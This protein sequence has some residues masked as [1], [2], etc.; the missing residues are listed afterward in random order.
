MSPRNAK[1]L[2]T[3]RAAEAAMRR[4]SRRSFLTGGIAA[5]VAGTAWYVLRNTGD[6][7]GI[8][9]FLRRVLGFN[10]RLARATFSD[11]RLAPTFPVERARE[12]RVNGGYGMSDVMMAA[13]WTLR[14]KYPAGN[15][16]DLPLATLAGLPRADI[17]AEFKCIEGWSEIVH[18]G[19]VRFRDFAAKFGPQIDSFDYVGIA[20]PDNG[21][22]VG[23]DAPSILHP[24]TIL[25]DTMNGAPLSARHGGPIRLIT[26][27]KYGVKNIKRIG[28]IAFANER[29]ADFWAERGYDWYLGL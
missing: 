10:E 5:S 22:Y 12:P 2:L 25:A 13:T 15:V 1:P 4:L 7:A 26:A 21:Y 3:G 29:P 20:T 8:P 16:R 23:M 6:A 18:W 14:L 17:V 9:W 24:Q 28:I 19:G 27:T 11:S